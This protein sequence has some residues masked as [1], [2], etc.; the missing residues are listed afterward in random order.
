VDARL[1][2]IVKIIAN[3]YVF[4]IKLPGNIH[5]SIFEYFKIKLFRESVK[6]EE[7]QKKHEAI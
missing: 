4:T 1:K 7:K 6:R 3:I 5:L 2:F